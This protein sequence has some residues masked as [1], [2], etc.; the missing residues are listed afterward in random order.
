MQSFLG[1]IKANVFL[2]MVTSTIVKTVTD[3]SDIVLTPEDL[4]KENLIFEGTISG[5]VNLILRNDIATSYTIHNATNHNVIVRNN[6]GAS[7]IVPSGATEAVLNDGAD[8]SLITGTSLTELATVATTGNYED[9]NHKPI[10]PV[11]TGTIYVSKTGNDHSG[12]GSEFNPYATITFAMSMI[13]DASASKHYKLKIGPGSYV[14]ETFNLKPFVWIEGTAV[15]GIDKSVS[16]TMGAGVN[17][18]LALHTGWLTGDN[19]AGISKIWLKD[20]D[21]ALNLWGSEGDPHATGN[22]R[23]FIDGVLVDGDSSIE[24]STYLDSC[25]IRNSNFEGATRLDNGRFLVNNSFFVGD[26]TADASR[27]ITFL[28]LYSCVVE[29]VLNV[30]SND[31]GN[32]YNRT[33]AQSSSLRG[34]LSVGGSSSS[35]FQADAVSF[36]PTVSIA[37]LAGQIS[38]NTDIY[39]LKYT[40][41]YE[42]SWD[43]TPSTLEEAVDRMA[44]LLKTLNNGNPIP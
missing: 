25:D 42:S 23:L 1:K 24:L 37:L 12:N 33:S 35:Y 30:V 40:T 44:S 9:L 31:D 41:V 17:S 28:D 29:G 21:L 7:V 43:N 8:V 18:T 39:G 11:F 5:D 27:A 3:T 16:I 36:P 6:T 22:N 10:G 14:N 20:S 38:R 4:R 13:L 34:G 2:P 15:N 32:V 19:W 26:I